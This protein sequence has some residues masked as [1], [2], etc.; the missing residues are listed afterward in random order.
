LQGDEHHV[1]HPLQILFSHPLAPLLKPVGLASGEEAAFAAG[2]KNEM[3]KIFGQPF[4]W[5]PSI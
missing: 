3:K 1:I 2:E 5:M 4:L